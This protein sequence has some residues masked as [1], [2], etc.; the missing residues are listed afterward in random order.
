MCVVQERVWLWNQSCVGLNPDL[1]SCYLFTNAFEV[2]VSLS[3][4]FPH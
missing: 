1:I 2:V 3:C 4:H